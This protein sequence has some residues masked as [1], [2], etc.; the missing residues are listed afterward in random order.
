MPVATGIN[1]CMCVCANSVYQMLCFW[2]VVS[3]MG[4]AFPGGFCMAAYSPR[5][6]KEGMNDVTCVAPLQCL[7]PHVL[8][9]EDKCG[10]F[11]TDTAV[12]LSLSLVHFNFICFLL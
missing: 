10:I 3:C 6:Q 7:F 4:V 5:R 1:A 11:N 9:D 8:L 2:L 12:P